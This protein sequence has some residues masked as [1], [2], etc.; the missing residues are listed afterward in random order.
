[1]FNALANDSR[2]GTH[3]Y[4]EYF[5]R[6][7][8]KQRIKEYNVFIYS[9][10]DKI[11]QSSSTNHLILHFGFAFAIAIAFA[12]ASNLLALHFSSRIPT[13]VLPNALTP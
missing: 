11:A 6:V 4:S 1:M 2:V 9:Y 7:G 10:I 8:H 12:S 5:S 3:I 13:L